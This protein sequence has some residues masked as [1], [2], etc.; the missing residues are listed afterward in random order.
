MN[1]GKGGESVTFGPDYHV[2]LPVLE[3]VPINH[4]S[5]SMIAMPENMAQI[6]QYSC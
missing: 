6:L 5:L 3:E 1:P 2:F 4:F